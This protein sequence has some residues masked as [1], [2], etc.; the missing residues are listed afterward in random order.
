M[1]SM[2]G[3]SLI[4]GRADHSSSDRLCL[5]RR[6]VPASPNYRSLENHWVGVKTTCPPDVALVGFALSD[7]AVRTGCGAVIVTRMLEDVA[8]AKHNQ[9][10]MRHSKEF[11]GWV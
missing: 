1:A 10:P 7:K 8:T 4:S 11:Y 2:R 5:F 6:T 3:A 9:Q